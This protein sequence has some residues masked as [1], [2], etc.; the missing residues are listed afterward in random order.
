M[1]AATPESISQIVIWRLRLIG[2]SPRKTLLGIKNLNDDVF[3]HLGDPL[4]K[5]AALVL[6]RRP[7]L[8][9]LFSGLLWK[10]CPREVLRESS[11]LPMNRWAEE[12]IDTSTWLASAICA[13]SNLSKRAC[14]GCTIENK[15]P[16]LFIP[17][18][19]LCYRGALPPLICFFHQMTLHESWRTVLDGFEHNINWSAL[20]AQ[21]SS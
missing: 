16:S 4:V 14:P 6:R 10:M 9:G 20:R 19:Q 18:R 7:Y 3:R 12:V 17:A 2:T 15:I 1:I 5:K 21:K 8:G 11:N 13:I